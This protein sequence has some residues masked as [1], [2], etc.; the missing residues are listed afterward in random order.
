MRVRGAAGNTELD[1]IQ[2]DFVKKDL[3]S[4]REK[5]PLITLVSAIALSFL[6]VT[7]ILTFSVSNMLN[8]AILL[9]LG[10]SL[11]KG[12]KWNDRKYLFS[13]ASSAQKIFFTKLG[14]SLS[15]F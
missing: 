8:G 9:T 11:A 4:F 12:I 5:Y 14:M 6:G 1:V 15:L 2:R 3:A 13:V 7:S 10:L